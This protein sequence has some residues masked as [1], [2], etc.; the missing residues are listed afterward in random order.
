MTKNNNFIPR[1][2]DGEHIYLPIES[3][4]HLLGHAS[5]QELL[6]AYPELEKTVAGIAGL[7]TESDYNKLLLQNEEAFSRHIHIEITKVQTLRGETESLMQLYPLKRMAAP[8]WF[9]WKTIE[10]GCSSVN[11]FIARYDFPDECREALNRLKQEK[12]LAE[13]YSKDLA[14]LNDP[15]NINFERLANCGLQI[16]ALTT[17]DSDAHMSLSCYL[18]GDGIFYQISDS[19]DEIYAEL[20]KIQDGRIGMPMLEG[21]EFHFVTIGKDAS[22]RDF[23]KFHIFE[24][25]RWILDH[26]DMSNEVSF[27]SYSGPGVHVDI[28]LEPACKLMNPNLFRRLIMIGGFLEVKEEMYITD[29]GGERVFIWDPKERI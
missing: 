3:C 19:G 24:N 29:P 28:D 23:R 7:I 12:Y 18:A 2:F 26:K 9:E 5:G 15:E 21:N 17:V 6:S 11:E 10:K 20:E 8:D 13:Q 25:L 4:A 16:Q 27:F 14:W 1:V 22:G